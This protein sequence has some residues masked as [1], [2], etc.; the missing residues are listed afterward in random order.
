MRFA[1]E[2]NGRLLAP[3]RET[4]GRYLMIGLTN[5]DPVHPD[6]ICVHW[7]ERR[8]IRFPD[9]PRAQCDFPTRCAADRT[10]GMT[11]PPQPF[12]LPFADA[13]GR[14]HASGR[15]AARFRRKPAFGGVTFEA[16]R[17]NETPSE[18]RGLQL[19]VTGCDGACAGAGAP[20]PPM[21]RTNATL[22]CIRCVCTEMYARRASSASVCAVTTSRYPAAPSR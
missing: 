7:T 20:P 16:F 22:A 18:T 21:A 11:P 5:C 14:S 13:R 10:R 6:P 2:L 8:P 9:A 12:F 3:D 17:L 15:Q 4:D 19:P 1:E